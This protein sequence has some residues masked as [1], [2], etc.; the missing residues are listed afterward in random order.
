VYDQGFSDLI[1]TAK[2]LVLDCCM[3]C[4]Q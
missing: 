4:E 1:T 3:A 2:Y